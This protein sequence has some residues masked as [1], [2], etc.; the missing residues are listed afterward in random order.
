MGWVLN[1]IPLSQS[2]WKFYSHV[3]K[4]V[5]TFWDNTSIFSKFS[6]IKELKYVIIF[7]TSSFDISSISEAMDAASPVCSRFLPSSIPAFSSWAC[8]SSFV[9]DRMRFS[10]WEIDKNI[11]VN[12][13]NL[14][15]E[16]FMEWGIWDLCTSH[17]IHYL[18]ITFGHIK[19]IKFITTVSALSKLN[20][21]WPLVNDKE[22]SSLAFIRI[23]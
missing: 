3:I 13:I 18:L 22:N 12:H 20:N 23:T 17:Y 7:L 5:S 14:Q 16:N 1:N 21:N 15:R 8:S 4:L 6:R 9:S 19:G 11:N 2:F 10:W